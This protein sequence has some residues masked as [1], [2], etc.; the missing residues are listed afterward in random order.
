MNYLQEIIGV[1]GN[2]KPMVPGYNVKA[3]NGQTVHIAQQQL[4]NQLFNEN[5]KVIV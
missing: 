4:M 2:Y 1:H 5:F 3:G